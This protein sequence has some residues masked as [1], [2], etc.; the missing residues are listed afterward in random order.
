MSYRALALVAVLVF[1]PGL[2]LAQETPADF[3]R[4][5]EGRPDF[6][7]LYDVAT[8]TP[9]ERP[10]E[11]EGRLH[12]TDEE[13]AEMVRYEEM[14]NERDRAPLDPNREA[15]PVG[16]DT[17]PTN[18]YLETLFRFGGGTVGG[19]NLFW[20]SPGERPVTIDGRARTSLIVDPEDGQVP[21][22]KDEARQRMAAL[23]ATAAAP[24]AGEGVATEE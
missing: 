17:S 7:G 19:Y 12:L 4:T 18:S 24:D 5:P 8:M 15:P 11:F 22:M 14:R 16:G 2:A 9:V 3:P 20:L 23:L 1:A 21:P 10:S 6:T 13:V